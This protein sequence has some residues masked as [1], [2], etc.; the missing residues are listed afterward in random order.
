MRYT[1]KWRP[2]AENI[3]ADIW[4]AAQDRQAIANAANEV[5]R[6]LERDAES[7]GTEFYGDLLIVVAPLH[8]VYKVASNKQVV[9]VLYL[10]SV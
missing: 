1:V 5:D 7:K 2:K 9:T 6:Q 3:L 10:W 4:T 8:V